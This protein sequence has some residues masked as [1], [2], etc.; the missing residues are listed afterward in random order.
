[1]S[2]QQILERLR[3]SPR[4]PATR[5]SILCS[6]PGFRVEGEYSLE[7]SDD[8]TLALIPANQKGSLTFIDVRSLTCVEFLD[9]STYLRVL[10]THVD[11]AP[12][13]EISRQKSELG[14]PSKLNVERHFA[15]WTSKKDFPKLV[16]D[17][18][19]GDSEQFRFNVL[20]MTQMLQKN[21]QD[22]SVAKAL[23]SLKEVVFVSGDGEVSRKEAT[24]TI[25]V[26][27][28]DYF[29]QKKFQRIYDQ[30]ESAL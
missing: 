6:G 28:S 27:G 19:S 17:W 1:M 23:A 29:S 30:C 16:A 3:A 13:E 12:Q 14:D 5:I 8:D 2:L 10:G 22:D 9:R 4:L 24:I 21:S 7:H 26:S 18:S 11:Q 15:L 20:G 25:P